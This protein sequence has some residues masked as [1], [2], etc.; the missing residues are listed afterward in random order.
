MVEV[1]N[2]IKLT[3]VRVGIDLSSMHNEENLLDIENVVK[4][5][6]IRNDT[7]LAVDWNIDKLGCEY[8]VIKP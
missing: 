7:N 2:D 4:T 5:S 3:T 1:Q 6:W 8:N